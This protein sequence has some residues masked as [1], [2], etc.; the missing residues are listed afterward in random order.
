M[1]GS[2]KWFSSQASF[3]LDA[4]Q[5]FGRSVKATS[6]IQAAR[7]TLDATEARLW[8]DDSGHR[9]FR[10]N[11]PIT[12]S[13]RPRRWSKCAKM[14]VRNRELLVRQARGFYEVGTRA[15]IDVARAEANL[16]TARA[17][18]IAAENGVK[19]AWVTLRQRHGFAAA[20]RNSRW[21]RIRLKWNSR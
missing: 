20:C 18:L 5:Q 9:Y 3:N 13:W 12:F 1:S 14:T 4:L 10:S 19:I 16:Y 2:C 8:H 15:R 21:L 11:S 17:D 6:D 7:E